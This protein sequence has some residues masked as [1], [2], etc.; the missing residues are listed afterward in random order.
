MCGYIRVYGVCMCVCVV[1][2]CF[3]VEGWVY[4]WCMCADR[5]VCVGVWC[6]GGVCIYVYIY[7]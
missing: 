3:C 4:V 5:S 2:V 1:R 7:I 6:V